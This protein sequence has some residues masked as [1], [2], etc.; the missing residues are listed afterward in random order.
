MSDEIKINQLPDGWE[1]KRLGDVVDFNP[2]EKLAK[3]FIAKKVAMEHLQPFARKISDYIISAFNGGSKF[4][5]R[6][7]L[8]ARITPCLENGKTSYVDILDE[9]EIGFGSTEYIVLREK[10]SLSDSKFIYYLSISPD[11]RDMAIKSMTGSSGRQRVQTDELINHT[12]N[13]PPLDEQK[14][15]AAVLSSLDDKIELN[16]QINKKLEEMAQAIFRQWFIDFNF[17]DEN[18]NPYRDSGGAMIDSELGQIPAGWSVGRLGDIALV[19]SGKRPKQ[20]QDKRDS[21]FNI[22][23]YG[24]S[25]VMGYVNEILSENNLLVIGRVGTHGVVNRVIGKS[26]LS[27][28]TLIIDSEYYNFL[29]FLLKNIDYSNLNRGAVQPLLTQTDIK[30]YQIIAPLSDLIIKFEEI[31]TKLF[32]QIN[33]NIIQIENLQNSRD[34]L[35]PKLMS[36]EIRL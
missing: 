1:V 9:N 4:R 25:G 20:R 23:L 35:L 7:T 13:L 15:I 10:Q 36:G 32:N 19:S 34:T 26:W 2:T 30:N 3:G 31:V 28:N 21:V 8:L 18:G 12:I 14:K 16:Q 33:N 22:P 27:D 6:D 24:A 5:N 17:P 11:F 29:Y